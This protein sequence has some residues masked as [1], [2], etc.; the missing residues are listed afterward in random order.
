VR[1]SLTRDSPSIANDVL[2]GAVVAA[3]RRPEYADVGGWWAGL[4]W[5]ERVR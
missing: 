2:G 1:C 5:L 3:S 4:R